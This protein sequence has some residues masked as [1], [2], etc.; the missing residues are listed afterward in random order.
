MPI[1]GLSVTQLGYDDG[2]AQGEHSEGT[3][4]QVGIHFEG[5]AL[6]FG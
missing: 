5:K 1:N 6:R 4:V 3:V 2:L